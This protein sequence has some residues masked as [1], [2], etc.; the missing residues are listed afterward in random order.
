MRL[1]TL[2]PAALVAAAVAAPVGISLAATGPAQGPASFS[3]TAL[4]GGGAT[5][6]LR[7]ALAGHATAAGAMRDAGRARVAR[8]HLRLAR[9]Y[10]ELTG[11]HTA[12]RAERRA[13]RLS[14]NRLRK[15][16]RALRADV[17]ELDIPVPAV[18]KRVAEC[19][20][21]GDPKAI[22]GGGTFRG[23]YQFMASTWRGVGGHGDPAA[24]PAKEQDRRAAILLARSGSSPWPVCGA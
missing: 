10:D 3:S 24:A 13:L 22:G 19:E 17:R 4:A 6:S 9:R 18:L 7:A 8:E 5:A 15:L 1:R 12:R 11:R 23:R 21:H 20:S 14:P 2:W 16:N